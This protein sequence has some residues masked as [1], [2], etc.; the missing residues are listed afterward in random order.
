MLDEPTS[1]LDSS[2]AFEVLSCIRDLVK[3][4]D[5]K[6]SV[7]LSIHQPNSRILE[8][9]D[10]LMLIDQGGT[11][12]FGSVPGATPYF[13]KIGFACP[14]SVTPTDYFL[15]VSDSNFNTDGEFD[16]EEAF[17]K[18][19]EHAAVLK[20]VEQ[21]AEY[22]K[23]S[24]KTNDSVASVN[25]VPWYRQFYV[26]VY[27]E[28]ALAYRDPTLYYFQVGL[29]ITFALLTGMVFYQMRRE[30][31]QLQTLSGGLLW[32]T[33]MFSWIHA[34]KVYHISKTD[35]RTVHE[36]SNG[37]YSATVFVFADLFASASLGVLFFPVIPISYFM[38]GF[39]QEGVGPLFVIL[40]MV[41]F[42]RCCCSFYMQSPNSVILIAK[43]ALGS[44]AMLNLICKFSHNATVS[45]IFAQIALVNLMVFAGGVF[46]PWDETPP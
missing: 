25:Q 44:E 5:G 42:T 46:I 6:L 30:I 13:S 36:V 16:F 19:A 1:G 7:M 15:Q 45:M 14:P 41:S 40:W 39:P 8:L 10:N 32:L 43:A 29:V 34:F 9:F 33:L 24:G 31:S 4:S 37:K 20:R 38:M 2:I 22:C 17:A 21:H 35:R 3:S 26:L 23:S 11:V 28:Y 12:Y 18:S 27:R